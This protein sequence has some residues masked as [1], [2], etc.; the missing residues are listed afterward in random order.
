[1]PK[2]KTWTIS[3][4][5]QF[6]IRCA[7]PDIFSRSFFWLMS[8]FMGQEFREILRY[9]PKSRR[10]FTR[11]IGIIDSMTPAE[12]AKPELISFDREYR[13]AEGSGV[14]PSEVEQ[15]LLMHQSL[16]QWHR[17]HGKH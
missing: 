14:E 4:T 6:L 11:Q 8:W 12:R 15:M 9:I 1:M 16:Q 7:Y 5:R 10:Y 17:E 2:S 13:I 3:D